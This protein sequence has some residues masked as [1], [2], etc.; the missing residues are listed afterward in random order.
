M[1]SLTPPARDGS[2]ASAASRRNGPRA[3][4]CAAFLVLAAT[5][6]SAAA[7]G[8]GLRPL[9]APTGAQDEEVLAPSDRLA[10]PGAARDETGLGQAFVEVASVRATGFVGELLAIEVRFGLDAEFLSSNVI[11]LF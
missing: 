4:S 1:P 2:A 5:A 6:G 11:P 8:T 9:Q 3:L 10:G 7:Q